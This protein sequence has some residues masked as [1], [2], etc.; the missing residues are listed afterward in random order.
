MYKLFPIDVK[1]R[2]FFSCENRQQKCIVSHELKSDK[3]LK[4]Y[5]IPTMKVATKIF[6]IF[7]CRKPKQ[8]Y[9]IKFLL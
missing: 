3:T 7:E 2:N 5:V 4:K 1:R 6:L 8:S 9:L